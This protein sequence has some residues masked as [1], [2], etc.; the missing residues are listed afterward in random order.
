MS[1]WEVVSE[2]LKK[3]SNTVIHPDYKKAITTAMPRTFLLGNGDM[4]VVSNGDSNSKE[5]LIS[6]GDF[7]SCGNLHTDDPMGVNPKKVTIITVGG[8]KIK[9]LGAPC[10]SETLD[11]STGE[12]VSV[13][14][15]ITFKAD[16][17][18]D[19]NMLVIDIVS[20]CD[21]SVVVESYVKSDIAEY[22]TKTYEKA[23]V[24]CVER[25]SAN[26]AREDK[27]SWISK[28]AMSVFCVNGEMSFLQ[29]T[30]SKVKYRLVLKKGEHIKLVVC[31]GGGG[32]TLTQ[33]N[34]WKSDLPYSEI[35]EMLR[36]I[37]VESL[38]KDIENTR[39]WWKEYWL[40]SYVDLGI[41]ELEKYYYGSL[42][43]TA[44]TSRD[45]KLATGLYGNLI[46][47]DNPQ[48][49]G[50][51]HLNYNLIAPF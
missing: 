25:Q 4:G 14:G 48:W 35:A 19:K 2:K 1:N 9:E 46:T 11:L 16:V 3:Y 31:M 34:G 18:A 49:Q 42:Y 44:I 12:L 21:K 39:S 17:I 5:Y 24:W 6:K 23:G 27:S 10:D 50:D 30:D 47:T 51:Y 8:V 45:G 40:R 41:E 26:F 13:Q 20:D 15:H 22:G 33:E 38:E 32:K 7:W 43:I 37:T 36:N 29:N 28:V